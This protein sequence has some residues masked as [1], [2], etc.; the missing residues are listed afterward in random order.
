MVGMD[1]P[2]TSNTYGK[3][4]D[5]HVQKELNKNNQTNKTSGIIALSLTVGM[6]LP[7]TSDTYSKLLFILP[8]TLNNGHITYYIRFPLIIIKKIKVTPATDQIELK[9]TNHNS[10]YITH[11]TLTHLLLLL[12]LQSP[13]GFI[14]SL[15]GVTDK[16][17]KINF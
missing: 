2:M 17:H 3:S 14:T 7:M 13:Y 1:L 8:L 15:L 4:R 10:T 16:G 9:I 11:H 5:S 6:D 12:L